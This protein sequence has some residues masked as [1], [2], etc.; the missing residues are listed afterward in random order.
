MT[1]KM[2]AALMGLLVLGLAI[3][4]GVMKLLESNSPQQQPAMMG[5]LVP[6]AVEMG[7]GVVIM[8]EPVELT[9][10]EVPE[11]V[12]VEE[13]DPDSQIPSVRF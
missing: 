12:V 11:A 2:V 1:I 8:E 3:G 10:P 13:I 5:E 9:E 4:V 7:E 6:E